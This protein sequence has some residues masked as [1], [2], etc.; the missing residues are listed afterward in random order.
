VTVP[1]TD[2][3]LDLLEHRLERAIR[4]APYGVL[5]IATVLA[6]IADGLGEGAPGGWPAT[7]ALVGLTAAWMLWMVTLH[8]AWTGRRPLMAVYCA[9][10]LVL[11][12]ALVFR[13]PLFGL[14][15]F[16]AYL[17]V[18]EFLAGGW[19]LAGVTAAAAVHVVAI[20]GGRLPDPTLASVAAF[21]LLVAVIAVMVVLFSRWGEITTEQNASASGSSPS[22]PRPTPG[23]RRPWP[24]MPSCR[25]GCWPRRGRR[26]LWTSASAWPARSTTP[27]PRA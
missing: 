10:L 3:R 12:A 16:V 5:A 15:V 2:A 8:P 19:R 27:W 18:W 1:Q 23:W 9:G 14:F 22:S 4:V 17:H 21:V 20:F 25:R 13:N 11:T 26:G 6:A 24:R 7:L